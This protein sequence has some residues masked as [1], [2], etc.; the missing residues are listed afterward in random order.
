MGLYTGSMT[1]LRWVEFATVKKGKERG[2][3]REMQESWEK[4]RSPGSA[5]LSARA[6]KSILD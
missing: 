1:G 6:Q 5:I 4:Y 3:Q 2:K